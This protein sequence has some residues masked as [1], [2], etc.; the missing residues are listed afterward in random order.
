MM[1]G[2]CQQSEVTGQ[3]PGNN[4]SST[5][6]FPIVLLVHM[7]ALLDIE[8][9]THRSQPFGIT[10]FL[11]VPPVSKACKSAKMP[12]PSLPQVS[13]DLEKLCRLLRRDSCERF[14]RVRARLVGSL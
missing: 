2:Y 7:S 1:R 3:E 5:Q 10:C 13:L 6:G 9:A 14:E 8:C 4:S 12:S 11:V